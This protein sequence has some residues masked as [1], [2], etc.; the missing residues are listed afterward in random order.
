MGQD[1]IH[2]CAEPDALVQLGLNQ[3]FRE[4]LYLKQIIKNKS[5]ICLIMDED[6]FCTQWNNSESNLRKFFDS[7]DL[8]KP[9]AD[10]DLLKIYK[11]PSKCFKFDPYAIWFMNKSESDLEKFRQYLGVWAVNTSNLTDDYF[12]IEHTRGYDKD[13][14]I[15]GSKNNGWGNYL[16]EIPKQLPPSNGIVF[17]DRHLL[18]NT[19]EKNAKRW[20]FYGLNNLKAL[21]DELLPQDLKIPYYI[22]IFCQHP[23]LDIATTDAIVGKFIEDVKSLRKYTINVEF[24]YAISR[25]KRGLHSNYFSFYT[26]RGFNAFCYNNLKKLNGENDFGIKSYLYNPFTSGD[27]EY[28]YAKGKIDKIKEQCIEICMDS[29]TTTNKLEEIKRVCTNSKNFFDNILFSID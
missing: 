14:T 11:D 3:N 28:K 6:E 8:A 16:S 24:V 13:D 20:G 21:F 26:D 7:Y 29:D 25:H 27:Y 2:I 1:K 5:E 4:G 15:E 17:N 19:N 22:L 18:F 23:K 9:K 12:Y 10:S